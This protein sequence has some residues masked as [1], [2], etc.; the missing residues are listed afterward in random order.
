MS[1]T[2]RDNSIFVQSLC[3]HWIGPDDDRDDVKEK[4][5]FAYWMA[6]QGLVSPNGD[7]AFTMSKI[8]ETKIVNA[9]EAAIESGDHG[10]IWETWQELSQDE[11]DF[12]NDHMDRH[13]RKRWKAAIIEAAAVMNDEPAP[14]P[15][16]P[17]L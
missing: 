4:L 16:M 14:E 11:M 6:T 17:E 13:R 15:V 3:R 2:D 9:M 10:K 1:W 5:R 12:M 7:T 8:A